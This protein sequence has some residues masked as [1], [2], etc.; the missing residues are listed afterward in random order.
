MD[1][2]FS[3]YLEK[4]HDILKKLVEKLLEKFE[5]VSLLATDCQGQQVT[6]S[7]KSINV[8]DSSWNERGFV[9][10]VFNDGI[11][12]EYSFDKITT[13]KDIYTKIVNSVDVN[14]PLYK[15]FFFE[16]NIFDIFKYSE[17]HVAEIIYSFSSIALLILDLNIFITS[18]VDTSSN[19]SILEK[20]SINCSSS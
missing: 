5:Y 9:V 11:Y 17:E 15:S 20:D 14:E 2:N 18:S 4:K 12:S 7:E 10:R 8:K 19:S 3:T 16:M 6:V 13:I 1:K